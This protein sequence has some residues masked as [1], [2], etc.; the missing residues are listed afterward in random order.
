MRPDARRR[1]ALGIDEKA[2]GRDHP[3]VAI[4]ANNVGKIL[5]DQG[6]LEGALRWVRR[7]L[8]ILEAT[9]GPGNPSTELTRRNLERIR[10][11]LR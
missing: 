2:L 5:K 8:R 10:K 1:R 4:R 3:K 6:D 9:Y 7:A 11:A